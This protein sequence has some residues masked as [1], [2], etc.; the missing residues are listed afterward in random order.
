MAALLFE[1][2]AKYYSAFKSNLLNGIE[3]YQW[4][5]YNIQSESAGFKSKWKSEIN[6]LKDLISEFSIGENGQEVLV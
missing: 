4:L 5:I 1:K 6:R 3:Y 2:Q